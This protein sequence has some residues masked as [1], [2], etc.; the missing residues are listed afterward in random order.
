MALNVCTTQNLIL[1]RSYV[2]NA[3]LL[4][5]LPLRI[6]LLEEL[7][8]TKFK[9]NRFYWKF[10]NKTIHPIYENTNLD[11][12]NVFLRESDLTK[13]SSFFIFKEEHLT[14]NEPFSVSEIFSF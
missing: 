7:T 5:R 8:L 9:N 13:F 3:I 2:V 10:A 11:K 6:V 4:V 12:Y 1:E 14:Q